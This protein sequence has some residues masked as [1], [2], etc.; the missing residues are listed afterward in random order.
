MCVVQGM[1]RSGRDRTRQFSQL[2]ADPEKKQSQDYF[3]GIC[4]SWKLTCICLPLAHFFF[5]H[6][7]PI[8]FRQ[9]EFF[10]TTTSHWQS[11]CACV[12][13]TRW[14]VFIVSQRERWK[15][16][17]STDRSLSWLCN[18]LHV[19]RNGS[20]SAFLSS[21]LCVYP[22]VSSSQLSHSVLNTTN[23]KQLFSLEDKL[24]TRVLCLWWRAPNKHWLAFDSRVTQMTYNT[25]AA[26]DMLLI[27]AFE[28]STTSLVCGGTVVLCYRFDACRGFCSMH[29]AWMF[30]AS[31]HM[32]VG[33]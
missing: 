10:S 21:K 8:L 15:K 25:A 27:K 9:T 23:V 26:V 3:L 19:L 32:P 29:L 13:S 33:L 31:I 1:K 6:P 12:W 7:W 20:I 30:S 24:I 4:W 11:M 17:V 5:S 14:Q 16:G 22:T 18:L 2:A 28:F